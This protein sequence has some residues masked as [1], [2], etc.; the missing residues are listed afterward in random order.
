M[1]HRADWKQC[2]V[3]LVDFLSRRLSST[4][5]WNA[6]GIVCLPSRIQ[7]F[8]KIKNKKKSRSGGKIGAVGDDKQ[9]IFFTRPYIFLFFVLLGG[10]VQFFSNPLVLPILCVAYKAGCTS[11]FILHF[12]A[13][14]I[15]SK[16]FLSDER[17][18]IWKKER[19]EKL[20]NGKSDQE[21]CRDLNRG[22]FAYRENAL[23][24]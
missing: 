24:T 9:L 19:R 4:F 18:N 16:I 5:R 14:H 12:E 2:S 20:P 21:T 10:P 1:G 22:P 15:K 23:P 17:L 8:L 6:R 3:K 11:R 7:V 13:A